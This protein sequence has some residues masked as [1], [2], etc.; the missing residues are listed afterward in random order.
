MET[1]V[2]HLSDPDEKIDR[3]FLTNAFLGRGRN[4]EIHIALDGGATEIIT[5]RETRH[6]TTVTTTVNDPAFPC[7][8]P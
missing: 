4:L 2:L 5:Y 1:V 8:C 7:G 6:Q 3:F